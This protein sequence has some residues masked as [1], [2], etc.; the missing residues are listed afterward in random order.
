M[1][2]VVIQRVLAPSDALVEEAVSLLLKAMEGDPFMY[3]ACEGNETTRAHMARMMVREHVCWGEFWTATEDDELVGFMTWFP[4]QSELA[5]P[6]D[7]RAKLAAPFM[8]ALSGDGKQYIAT[9]VRFFMSRLIGN[10][11]TDRVSPQMGEEFPQFV[12]QCIGTPNGK[13]DGW[14]LRI[15]MTRTDKQR[16]GICRKL[17]EPVRQKVS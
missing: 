13:H 3:V 9:V 6:K 14:W 17:L 12:A 15:A 5:I 2:P 4:P 16:Q 10:H 7:E 1:S 8:A 11:G